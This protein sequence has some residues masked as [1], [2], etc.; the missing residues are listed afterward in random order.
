MQIIILHVNVPVYP[1]TGF[2]V[3]IVFRK[4]TFDCTILNEQSNEKGTNNVKIIKYFVLYSLE[5][6]LFCLLFY[7]N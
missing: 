6:L 5:R 3:H 4:I 7:K 2:S 1:L